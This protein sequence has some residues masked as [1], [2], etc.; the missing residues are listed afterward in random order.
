MGSCKATTIIVAYGEN[1]RAVQKTCVFAGVCWAITYFDRIFRWW[2]CISFEVQVITRVI[3]D[4]SNVT[5]RSYTKKCAAR[6][7]T[8][9]AHR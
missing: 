8:N 7:A 4:S 6:F 2:R 9:D 3:L 5:G 1:E